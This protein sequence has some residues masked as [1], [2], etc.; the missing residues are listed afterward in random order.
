MNNDLLYK[1]A[2]TLVP[3]IGTV[4]ARILVDHFGDAS[5]IFKAKKTSLDALE[6][7]G[8][9]RARNIKTFAG[10]KRVEEEL[11][12]IEKY[13]ITPLFLTDAAYPKRLLNCYDPPTMLYYRGHADLNTSRIIA[14][15]GTRSKTE[16]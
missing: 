15:V 12:F 13:K 3:N 5:A 1:I 16:Y 11:A 9:I 8:E 2:L 10:F 4:Q 14:I 7:I 6:G